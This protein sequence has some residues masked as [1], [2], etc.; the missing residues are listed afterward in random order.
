VILAGDN[1]A[2]KQLEVFGATA[3]QVQAQAA[4]GQITADE[5]NRLIFHA[6]SV[7]QAGMQQ[8]AQELAG[9]IKTQI[10]ANGGK[11]VAV[12]NPIDLR[13][14][15]FYAGLAS[16]QATA[17]GAFVASGLVDIFDV[18][19]RDGLTGTPVQLINLNPWVQTVVASPAMYG[20]TNVTTPACSAA[21]IS[22]ITSG[23]I[24]SGSSLFCNATPG[25]PYN[26]LV[27]GADATTWLWAD[28]VHPATGAQ[29]LLGAEI[30]K[31][32]QAFGWI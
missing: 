10:L 19:L 17:P 2:F 9:Y 5:A 23:A 11:Y 15:P 4:A 25:A 7:A 12:I 32:L 20:F 21:K 16:S 27:A 30:I 22:A 6:Q 3:A 31:Q 14:T 24:T 13:V 29:A 26:G 28:D 8:A 18:W 1:E